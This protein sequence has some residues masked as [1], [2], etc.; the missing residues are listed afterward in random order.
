M[1]GPH[2]SEEKAY[3]WIDSYKLDPEWSRRRSDYATYGC[4]NFSTPKYGTESFIVVLEAT[5]LIT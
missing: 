4:G 5:P 2:A 3:S 1:S